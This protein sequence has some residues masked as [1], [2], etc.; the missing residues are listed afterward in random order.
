MSET[1]AVPGAQRPWQDDDLRGRAE[2]PVDEA[3]ASAGGRL[4][5][6]RRL[7][8]AERAVRVRAL[9]QAR[10]RRWFDAASPLLVALVDSAT[11]ADDLRRLAMALQADGRGATWHIGDAFGL[12]VL[13][14]SCSR[15]PEPARQALE[16]EVRRHGHPHARLH[17][18]TLHPDEDDLLPA[19][20]EALHART[21]MDD[22][23][24]LPPGV[25]L[26]LED[27]EVPV[28]LLRRASPG[29]FALWRSDDDAQL[30]TVEAYLDAGGRV[31][32]AC[33]RLHIHRTTLYY[34]LENLP[35]VVRDELADGLRRSVMHVVLTTLRSRAAGE[36][37]A[38]TGG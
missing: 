22:G 32:E 36:D 2:T 35:E 4:R 13:V 9:A 28:D 23:L 33:R 31:S 37:A 38:L 10:E 12:P 34:R 7:L 27:V 18:A 24:R 1:S 16:R 6:F 21:A 14:T 8:D 17:D 29:A 15:V 20:R 30:A 11:S 3:Q 5:V 25:R 26:L 19:V